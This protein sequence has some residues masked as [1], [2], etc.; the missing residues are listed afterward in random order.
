MPAG[1]GFNPLY[2]F[3]VLATQLRQRAVVRDVV[4]QLGINV[5]HQ[6]TP[7]SPKLPSLLNGLPAPLVIGPMNGGMEYPPGFRFLQ[8]RTFRGVKNLTQG[9]SNLLLWPVDAK[10]RAECLV[11]VNQR[12]EDG[13]PPGVRGRIFTMMENGIIAELWDRGTP[14]GSVPASRPFELIFIGR[15]ERWKG[16]EWAIE[17]VARA[18]KRI[19][20]R[21]KII[22]ELNDERQRLTVHA[23]QLGIES[24]VEF[25]GWQS[26]DRCAEL[27]SKADA[28]VLPSVFE[29]GGAVVLEAMA[30]GKP[31]IAAK[32]GGP[33]DILDPS[34]GILVEPHDPASLVEGFEQAIVSLAKDRERCE[35]MGR[36]A[37]AK[38]LAQYTWPTKVEQFVEIYRQAIQARAMNRRS[39]LIMAARG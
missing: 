35:S 16:P 11:V 3:Q 39:G 9:L 17:A 24:Q 14:G 37:K 34:C 25:L 13:L 23:A 2:Y 18:C 20:C 33:A 19:D 12:T 31:V 6:P 4:K 15:L 32:W 30:A 10:R 38:V 36:A 26:Q 22:G 28:M 5:V 21:L 7:V 8:R 27:L 1:M 29:C